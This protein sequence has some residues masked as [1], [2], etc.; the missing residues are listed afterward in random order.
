MP[1]YRT[2]G[3]IWNEMLLQLIESSCVPSGSWPATLLRL[4]VLLC[5][6][7]LQRLVPGLPSD[8]TALVVYFSSC[9]SQQQLSS[10]DCVVVPEG[11][12]G[13]WP[14][15]C[16]RYHLL[17]PLPLGLICTGEGGWKHPVRGAGS[18]QREEQL[19]HLEHSP[20]ELVRE[21]RWGI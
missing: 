16:L 20:S 17:A 11:K 4:R 6:L 14:E 9:W 7:A 12:R 18:K 1:C 19:V 5:L 3:Q 13:A 10:H 2:C 15:I 8:M 21:G